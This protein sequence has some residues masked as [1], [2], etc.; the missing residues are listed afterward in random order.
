MNKDSVT[1]KLK[2]K[3]NELGVDYDILFSLMNF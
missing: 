1:Q 3:A 2:N